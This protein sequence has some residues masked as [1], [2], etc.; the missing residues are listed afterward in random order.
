MRTS[1]TYSVSA[2]I[3][4]QSVNV[5]TLHN[6]IQTTLTLSS[7]TFVGVDKHGDVLYIT[8]SDAITGGEKTS[9]DTIVLNHDPTQPIIDKTKSLTIFPNTRDV[10]STSYIVIGSFIY[11]G[12]NTN[13]IVGIDILSK[14]EPSVTSYDV[15]IVEKTSNQYITTGNFT[16][17]SYQV[18]SFAT[19]SNI[20]QTTTIMDISCRINKTGTATKHAIIEQVILWLS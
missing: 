8:F 15:T 13:N 19:I 3:T 16:N 18:Q 4:A 7:A 11:Q 12:S 17:D 5:L 10:T 2:D 14:K 20:P 1:Y 9:L 6:T